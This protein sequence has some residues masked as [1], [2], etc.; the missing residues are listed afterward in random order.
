APELIAD[1]LEVLYSDSAVIRFR[2]TCPELKIYDDEDVPFKEFPKGFKM[3]QYDRDKRITSS[4]A[5]SYGKYFE[6]KE[7]WEAKQ[8]VV[9]VTENNDTLKTELLYWDEKK[10]KI[11]SDQFVKFIRK[12]QIITG[13]GF[14]SDLQMKNWK[15]LKVQG[16]IVVEVEE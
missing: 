3:E 15:I 13:I 12:E 1:T 10:E 6:E 2:L 14:E 4:I 5:A 16:E 7:L 9:A 8:N 11:Y